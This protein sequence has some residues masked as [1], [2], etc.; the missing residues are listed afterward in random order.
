MKSQKKCTDRQT[1]NIIFLPLGSIKV[2]QKEANLCAFPLQ[3]ERSA[4]SCT[5]LANLDVPREEKIG[6]GQKSRLIET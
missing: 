5:L 1:D 3:R 2:G 4:N 6:T